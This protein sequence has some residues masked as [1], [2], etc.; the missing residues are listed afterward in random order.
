[1]RCNAGIMM[2]GTSDDPVQSQSLLAGAKNMP[3]QRARVPT[4][5]AFNALAPSCPLAPSRALAA[6]LAG[7]DSTSFMLA[8]RGGGSLNQSILQNILNNS[9]NDDL[10]EIFKE[11]EKKHVRENYGHDL[12][13]SFRLTSGMKML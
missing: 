1:M 7:G 8:Y 9:S 3:T 13:K 5:L 2:C 10:Q 11:S 12:R 4:R 6:P